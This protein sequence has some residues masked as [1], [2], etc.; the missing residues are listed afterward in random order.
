MG[1]IWFL[2]HPGVARH[3]VTQSGLIHTL[4]SSGTVHMLCL[5]CSWSHLTGSLPSSWTG[6]DGLSAVTQLWLY[7]NVRAAMAAPWAWQQISACSVSN[8]CRHLTWHAGLDAGLGRA[9]ATGLGDKVGSL[10]ACQQNRGLKDTCVS[11]HAMQHLQPRCRLPECARHAML[12]QAP[13]VHC[14]RFWLPG[15]GAER[16]DRWPA[17]RAQAVS[18]GR[19]SAVGALLCQIQHGTDHPGRLCA[20]LRGEELNVSCSLRWAVTM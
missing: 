5:D 4:L 12:A 1:S 10:L 14:R 11:R 20:A 8:A 6:W 13:Q 19:R 18:G 15:A 16:C 3:Q 17:G 9:T 7:Q 2:R